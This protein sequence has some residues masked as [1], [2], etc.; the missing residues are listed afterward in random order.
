M[1]TRH[2]IIRIW[3]KETHLYLEEL[4]TIGPYESMDKDKVFS[5]ITMAPPEECL[6]LYYQ[7]EEADKVTGTFTSDELKKRFR[8]RKYEEE[9]EAEEE[10]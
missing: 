9:K 3:T 7:I 10:E 5:L 4:V 1:G 6:P 8:T 2:F